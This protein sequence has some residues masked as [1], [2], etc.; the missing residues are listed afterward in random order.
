MALFIK[1]PHLYWWENTR[2]KNPACSTLDSY[3]KTPIFTLVEITEDVVKSVA[4]KVLGSS[5]PVGTD[6][7]A[8]QGWLLK[9]GDDIKRICTSFETSVVWISNKSPTWAAYFAFMSACLV[10]HYK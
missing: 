6:L 10:V 1:T 7:E 5:G 9:F 2:R 4:R 8:I 3:N